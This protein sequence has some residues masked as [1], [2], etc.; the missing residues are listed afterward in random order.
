MTREENETVIVHD[1]AKEKVF[2]YTTRK[3]ERRNLLKRIGEENV[4]INTKR[5]RSGDEIAW[6][7]EIDMEY[8]RDA[9]M[10]TK[11]IN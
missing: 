3:G 11:V 5:N 7:I 9:Y 6:E 10:V 8:C 1:Y 4:K 2:F